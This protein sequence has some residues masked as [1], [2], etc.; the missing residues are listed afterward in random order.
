MGRLS[1]EPNLDAREHRAIELD[2]QLPRRSSALAG[3]ELL[4]AF[5]RQLA[6]HV[7]MTLMHEKTY[8]VL[9]WSGHMRAEVLRGIQNDPPRAAGPARS[10]RARNGAVEDERGPPR[11]GPATPD[12]TTPEGPPAGDSDRGRTRFGFSASQVLLVLAEALDDGLLEGLGLLVVGAVRRALEPL[13]SRFV[14]GFYVS[15]ILRGKG[16]WGDVVMAAEEEESPPA[17]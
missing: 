11:R 15:E 14:G 1:G 13:P 10:L 12:V 3:N 8:R 7:N 6:L 17:S 9:A 5:S 2:R 4:N 16:R